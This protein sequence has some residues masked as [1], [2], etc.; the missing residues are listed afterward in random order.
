MTRPLVVPG[1]TPRKTMEV[2]FLV[3]G[4][5]VSN[6][7]FIERIF[8]NG[9]DPHLPE[10]DAGLDIEGWTGHTGYVILAPHL[11]TLTKKEL[12]L[13]HF[14]EATERQKRDRICWASPDERYNNGDA[15]KVTARDGQ[16]VM[17]TVIADNYYGYCKKEVKTQVSFAA[18][19]LGM[20]E[21]EHAGGAL[22]HPRYD[23]G[24]LFSVATHLPKSGHTFENVQRL[25]GDRMETQKEG[26]GIDKRHPDIY[27][28]PENVEI[29]LNTQT[30]RWQNL[31]GRHALPLDPEIT[32]V[33][34]VGY[35]V[36]LEKEADLGQWRLVGTTA[37]GTLSVHGA[38][39]QPDRHPPPPRAPGRRAR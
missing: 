10:S 25:F 32:Y 29:N 6:V 39:Q 33:V 28:V 5:L 14:D 22:V 21:E 3:P 12:G 35:K 16:G 11:P 2:R 1:V 18:D 26:Y 38:D 8:G 19:L 9:G 31:S 24:K 15:F 27:Y 37:E 13:P 30:V 34:P 4:N 20:V 17:V 7:D 23:L 36:R